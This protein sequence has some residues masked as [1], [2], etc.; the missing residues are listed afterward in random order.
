MSP[1]APARTGWSGAE[2]RLGLGVLLG[3]LPVHL[4]QIPQGSDSSRVR[5]FRVLTVTLPQPRALL[6]ASHLS[7]YFSTFQQPGM[8]RGPPPCPP[9]PWSKS[10]PLSV[11]FFAVCLV[12]FTHLATHSLLYNW[13]ALCTTASQ[14]LG[15]DEGQKPHRTSESVF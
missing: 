2:M 9:P 6:L 3:R 8:T 15:D 4:G 10:C 1:A 12:F 5:S 14:V 7:H 13:S 11:P